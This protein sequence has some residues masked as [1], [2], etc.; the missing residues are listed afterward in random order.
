[1]GRRAKNEGSIRQR[2]DGRWEA[3]ATGSI[4]YRTGK[5]KRISVYG[6]TKSEV[7]GK[8]RELEYNIHNRKAI[9]PTSTKFVDWLT[10]WLETYKRNNIKQSTYVSYR[11]Y[12]DRHVATGFPVMKLKD[13]TSRDLQEFYN[14]KLT[15]E[16]LSAKTILNIH[17]CLHEALKQAVLEHYLTYNPSDAV[18]LPKREK[19][20]IEILTREEQAKLIQASYQFRYGIFIRLTLTTGMRLGEVL[21]LKWEN[22]DLRSGML[23]VR[24]TLNRLE[25]IDYNGIGSKT[26]IVFQVPKTKNS[27]RSI[28][29]LPFMIKELRDWK[30]VQLSDKAQAGAAYQDTGM[31]VTNPF[32][33]YIE[34]RTFKDYYNQILQASG[35]GHYTFHALRHT[36]CTRALENDMDAKT[37]STIMGHY[38]VAFTLD[39]YGHVLDS[40][41]RE[42]MMKMEN[43]FAPPTS[44]QQSYPVVVTPNANGFIL[45]VVDFDGLSFEADNIQYGLACIQDAITEKLVGYCPPGPTPCTDLVLSNGEFVIMITI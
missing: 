24:Q 29:L 5:P 23:H 30:N 28:P 6:K 36:F 32:G 10:Y 43:I 11:G 26:E 20:E 39:V 33:G 21:G 38:S 18:V 13:L 45:N 40:H 3:R 2:P 4:D 12:I 35:I 14:Y 41:K 8:L 42:E 31:V 1:M 9:D 37:V 25:K 17:R 34:P 16:N 19:P 44:Q 7:I 15:V 27:I 22:I